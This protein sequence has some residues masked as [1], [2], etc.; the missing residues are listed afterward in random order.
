MAVL[1]GLTF[2]SV[3]AGW[4][5]TCGVTTSAAAYCWGQGGSSQLGDKDI[6]DQS[7]ATS[8]TPVLVT[9]ELT[10]AWVSAGEEYTCGV[11]TDGGAFC[12]GS[13]RWGRLGNGTEDRQYRPTAVSGRLA[14]ASVSAGASH[15]CGVTTSGAAH[16][17]GAGGV[18]E[19]GNGTEDNHPMPVA[20][21]GGLTF[22]TVSAGRFHTCGVTTSGAGYCW[23]S[24]NQGRLGN[25]SE[26]SQTTPVAIGSPLGGQ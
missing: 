17:W 18:G 19:L 8:T 7:V 22:A 2:A 12:W 23:G 1:G 5:H 15:T 20:V 13:G 10:F 6:T 16:C 3:S 21:S 11:P 14:F 24:G 9:V 26:S 25:G 4:D